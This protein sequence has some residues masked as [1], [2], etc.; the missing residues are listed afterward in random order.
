MFS[1][2]AYFLFDNPGPPSPNFTSSSITFTVGQNLK[3]QKWI[4]P[5]YIFPII[6]WKHIEKCIVYLFIAIIFFKWIFKWFKLYAMFVLMSFSVTFS[7]FESMWKKMIIPA[8][9]GSL[10]NEHKA[11]QISC[12]YYLI[13]IS[14]HF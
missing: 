2:Y 1:L 6:Q 12:R 11:S 4:Y 5:K 3:I 13:E 8:K 7:V 14:L 9:Y 10:Q